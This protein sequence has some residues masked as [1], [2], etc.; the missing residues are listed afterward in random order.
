M[1]AMTTKSV[2]VRPKPRVVF[3]GSGSDPN[4]SNCALA[5]ESAMPPPTAPNVKS[6]KPENRTCCAD[7]VSGVAASTSATRIRRERDIL[8]L[9]DRAIA[10]VGGSPRDGRAVRGCRGARREEQDRSQLRSAAPALP[11]QQLPGSPAHVRGRSGLKSGSIGLEAGRDGHP[12]ACA[13]DVQARAAGSRAAIRESSANSGTTKDNLVF[14]SASRGCRAR[15]RAIVGPCLAPHAPARRT[16]PPRAPSLAAAPFRSQVHTRRQGMMAWTRGII[17]AAVVLSAV[18]CGQ[19][20]PQLS[21]APTSSF[22]TQSSST[23]SGCGAITRTETLT[24]AAIGGVKPSGKA[25]AT[26]YRTYCGQSNMLVVTVKS[27]NYPDGTVLGVTLDWS[28]I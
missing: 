10:L 18:G 8:S 28:P 26:M 4:R 9:L 13:A 1:S 27:V 24:G 22:E 15:S 2:P 20:S 16:R 23:P 5:A 3:S 17:A 7:A 21:T 14:R 11:D 6:P 12:T 25:V 19:E